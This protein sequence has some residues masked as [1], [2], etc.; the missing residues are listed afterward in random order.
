M[1]ATGD[2]IT[3]RLNGIKYL[4]KPPLHYWATAAAFTLFGEHQWTARLWSALT[5]LFGVLAILYTGA[6]LFGAEAGLYGALVL[7]S[8]FL[9][10]GI[11][12]LNTLDT[13]TTFF[14]I[15]ALSGSLLAP[16]DG[17]TAR[18]NAAWMLGGWSAMG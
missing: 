17:V 13:G 8:S 14:M 1:V 4:E 7:G 11:A 15:L 2:W 18:Q 9:Y 16:R 12:H 6:A 5:G 3:P 10:V